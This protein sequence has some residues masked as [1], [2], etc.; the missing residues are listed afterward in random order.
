MVVAIFTESF[1]PAVNGVSVSVETFARELT[2]MGHEVHVFAPRYQGYGDE[3][4]FRVHRCPSVKTPFAPDY[5]V[6]IPLPWTLM[7]AARSAG[8][9]LVHTQS[10]FPAG[11]VGAYLARRLEVPF[12]TTYHTVYEHYVHYARCVPQ[13]VSKRFVVA[14]SRA[15]CNRAD[16]V[17]VPTKSVVEL[18]RSYGVKTPIRVV[19]T[20]V[21]VDAAAHFLPVDLRRDLGLPE[22]ARVV[23]YAGRVAKEKSV[24][25]LLLAF[26][27]IAKAR[28]DVYLVVA[29]GGPW[30][31][32]LKRYAA[33]LGVADRI[34]FA[35]FVPR[36]KLYGYYRAADLMLYPSRT[37]TQ[38]LVLCEALAAGL[39]CVAV[40]ILGPSWVV[41]HGLDGLLANGDADSLANAAL[42]LL[43]D[44]ERLRRMSE[45]AREGAGRF[46]RRACAQSLLGAYREAIE[47]GRR[48]GAAV[49][50]GGC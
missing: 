33:A 26:A 31:D 27:R 24:D 11:W 44:P 6:P 41:R 47:A 12:V 21:D 48:R 9:E 42:E 20:G 4:P 3:W 28:P 22:G 13:A 8:I 18:L 25:T 17:I 29:G 7:Q 46:S 15:Y 10:P 34:R 38:G 37:D 30:E 2:E 36:Q 23:L 35:G 19:A 14:L 16:L 40:G 49:R 5:R 50:A 39:P 32:G 1:W 45:S 43:A